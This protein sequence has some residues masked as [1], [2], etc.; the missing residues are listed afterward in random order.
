M[1]NAIFI[2]YR[3]DD[4]EGEAGRL[5]DDLTRAFGAEN[6]F[7]DVAGIRPG[8]DFR[9]A[10][11]DNVAHCGVLL[12]IV[13]PAWVSVADATGQRRIDNPSDFVALEIG[14]ALKR[15]VPVIPV[16]VH[17]AHMPSHDQLPASLEGFSYRNSVELT[18]ARWN[19]DVQ[20]LVEAL[21]AYVTPEPTTVQEPVHATVPV[22]LPAPHPPAT[23]ATSAG[24]GAAR[25]I[26]IGAAVL[27]LLAIAVGLYF[28]LRPEPQ[29]APTPTAALAGTWKEPDSRSGDSIGLLVIS[30]SGSAFT[31]HAFGTCQANSCDWGQQSAT[32]TGQDASATFTPPDQTGAPDATRTAVVSVHRTGSN[33]DVTVQNTFKEGSTSRNKQVHRVFVSAQ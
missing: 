22:Q 4:T 10:I 16:L 8:V 28:F 5:F 29:P 25:S 19:S 23:A 14:S 30:G 18:H 17:G 26:I 21:A 2:S 13:G 33:L 6:V 12:A 31:M 7:M 3:R 24:T 1:G 15:E 11:E 20:L 9:T 32:V 27:V